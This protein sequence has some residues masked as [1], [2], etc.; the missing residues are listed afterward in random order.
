MVDH[1]DELTL[2]FDITSS[3]TADIDSVNIV[4]D[5]SVDR[6]NNTN[7]GV[8]VEDNNHSNNDS[9]TTDEE[10]SNDTTTLNHEL[11]KYHPSYQDYVRKM[12]ISKCSS[13]PYLI[14]ASSRASSL[15]KA[16]LYSQ[17]AAG[18]SVTNIVMFLSGSSAITVRSKLPSMPLLPI[19]S[20]IPLPLSLPSSKPA[21]VAVA[22]NHSIMHN[23]KKLVID[24][25]R[26][27]RVPESLLHYFIYLLTCFMEQCYSHLVTGLAFAY[28]RQL[29]GSFI[30]CAYYPSLADSCDTELDSSGNS[31]NSN[32]SA[33]EIDEQLWHDWLQHK[34]PSPQKATQIP[35]D[36]ALS[37]LQQ[38]PWYLRLGISTTTT[39]THGNDDHDSRTMVTVTHFCN[40]NFVCNSIET[41]VTNF[42]ATS[43]LTKVAWLRQYPNSFFDDTGNCYTVAPATLS[44]VPN[45]V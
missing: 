23:S 17:F 9:N 37:L 13:F 32:I 10:R 2:N 45:S 39:A 28:H 31:N 8:S 5:D 16:W 41:K 33:N 1:A 21:S 43:M 34:V 25:Y 26:F 6:T 4:T 15:T 20:F 18:N 12:Y 38:I 22:N 14:Y 3:N 11:D 42:I 30:V 35:L 7:S 27:D 19:K 24:K 36:Q 44:T 29:D 40:C